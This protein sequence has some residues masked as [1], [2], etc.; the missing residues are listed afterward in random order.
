MDKD[1]DPQRGGGGGVGPTTQA[2]ERYPDAV[3][4]PLPARPVGDAS[5]VARLTLDTVDDAFR[6]Q[7]WDEFQRDHGAQVR[8]ALVAA[9]KVILRTVPDTPLRTRALNCLIDARML[10]NASISFRGRF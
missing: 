2:A 7:R 6:Y 3:A 8:D 4:G 10:A 1:K 9:A 5:R